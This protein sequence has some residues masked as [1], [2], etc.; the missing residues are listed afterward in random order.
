M[1]RKGTP[2]GQQGKVET[3]AKV[4]CTPYLGRGAAAQL[5][6]AGQECIQNNLSRETR[7]LEVIMKH[8][9]TGQG[10]PVCLGPPA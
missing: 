7:V 1:H 2:T 4:S 9:H 3:V 10:R 8:P 6:G 5:T